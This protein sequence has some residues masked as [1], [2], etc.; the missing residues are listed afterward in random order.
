MPWTDPNPGAP[1]LA[2]LLREKACPEPVE[3]WGFCRNGERTL[4]YRLLQ[5]TALI[6]ISTLFSPAAPPEKHLA[7]YSVAANYSLPLLQREGHTY[8][9]LLEVLEP[10]GKVSAK[11][12]GLRWR[13]RYN[14]SAEGIFQ[15]GKTHARVQGRDADLT[16]R[17]LVEN[18]RGLV[19]LASLGSLL[20]ALSR[21]PGHPP[22]SLRTPL[23]RQ[24]R[25]SLHRLALRRKSSPPHLPFHRARESQRSHRTRRTPHDLLP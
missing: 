4:R 25:H 20:P 16:G 19:P 12:E 17:F 22:R 1:F 6:L 24:R 9:G 7:V 8:V 11:Q 2:R 21:R 10:L 13:L 3:G 5:V 14:N 18:N 15:I 23:H